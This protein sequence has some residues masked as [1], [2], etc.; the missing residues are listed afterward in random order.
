MIKN[1]NLDNLYKSYTSDIFLNDI[2]N[3][4]HSVLNFNI[5]CEKEL[6]NSSNACKKLETYIKKIN[7]IS[8]FYKLSSY[9][10]LN[11]STDTTNTELL[12]I[13]SKIEN[14]MID[15]KKSSI[16]L[17]TFLKSVDNLDSIIES[18]DIL[19][20]HRFILKEMK[21]KSKYLLGEA[22]EMC[23]AKMTINGSSMWCKQWQQLT[24]TLEVLHD[25]SSLTLSDIRS[26]AQHKDKNV[27]K[28]AYLSELKAYE[29]ISLP[30]SFSLNGIKGEVLEICSMK[31]FSSPLDMSL[32]NARLD[33]KIFDAMMGCIKDNLPS[34]QKYFIKKASLL[35]HKNGL[36]FYDLFAPISED[37]INF[38]YDEAKQYIYKNFSKFSKKLGDFS[39]KAFDN[40][41]LDVYSKK[42]KVG[43][44]FCHSI[45]SIAESRI[46]LNF[47]NTL[48]SVLTIAHELGHAYHNLCLPKDTPLNCKYSMPIA[49]TASTFCESIIIN[50][51]LE[52]ANAEEKMIILENDLSGMLQC[53]VDIYS[54]FL[55]E[56]E[57]FK[58]RKNGFV[59]QDELCEIMINA[60]K[61]AYGK[62]LDE[63][64]L[65]KY[66]WVCKT[67]YYY[68]DSNYYNF[69]YAYGTLFSK[70][71][72]SLYQK[73]KD[74]FLKNY[75][76]M[77]SITG[78]ASLYDVGKF[79]NI[80]LTC[81]DFWQDSLNIIIKDIEKYCNL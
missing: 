1:W 26:L 66:M 17:S 16:L 20:A 24:S 11:L 38:T 9:V 56:D 53:I 23:I 75:D 81:K 78:K 70:G 29:K 63:N 4:S 39:K 60:Q 71:L 34:L 40:D 5:W 52:E 80:D 31:G 65:H 33:K 32:K 2:K 69:P 22:E 74:L 28:S 15:L 76:K 47:S 50:S 41:W 14:I 25:K 62:G 58:R 8:N 45:H 72:F 18:S 13:S 48:D 43:G 27:R 46:L 54:R 7:D 3:F 68:A 36:P 73:D 55:F 12:N 79:L 44:A 67:H 49:E 57:V 10:S 64:Y 35:G 21:E 59:S 30:A 77:L 19:K 37:N 61:S 42:G 6:K 51:A